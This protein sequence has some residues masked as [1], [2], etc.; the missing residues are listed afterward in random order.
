V[1]PGLPVCL[2][3]LLQLSFPNVRDIKKSV[4]VIV[5]TGRNPD[6]VLCRRLCD[7][8]SVVDPDLRWTVEK[9]MNLIGVYA[10]KLSE[11][12]PKLP[13]K[14]YIIFLPPVS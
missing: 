14:T 10:T 2:D 12:L 6:P 5:G 11:R 13:E 9:K 8:I 7:F 4:T 1:T 3:L